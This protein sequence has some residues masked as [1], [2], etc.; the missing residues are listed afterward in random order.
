M[1][2]ISTVRDGH[3]TWFKWH[4]A[5]RQ[6]SDPVFTGQRILEGMR[7]GASVEVDLR[8]HRDGGFAVLHDP[9]L[10]DETTGSGR[11]AEQSPEV[12]RALW[13]RDN[14]GR[15]TAH[16]LMLLEDLAALLAGAG[17]LDPRALLQLDLKEDRGALTDADI[18]AFKRIVAPVA[19]NMILSGGDAEAV[20]VLSRGVPGLRVGYDPCHE[21]KLEALLATRD[22]DGFVASALTDCPEA[23]LIYLDYRLVLFAAD[24]GYDIVAAFH[25]SGKRIDAYTIKTAG[26]DMGPVIERLLAQRVDQITTDDPQG[27]GRLTG[28]LAAARA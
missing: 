26:P 10:D 19:G 9:H 11:V 5:R 6:A 24:A 1:G 13:L 4:R 25:A 20:K 17:A 8:K 22:F 12:L 16:P 28:E 23:E 21:G 15:P 14:D 3:L 27:L 18:A 7:E 2:D